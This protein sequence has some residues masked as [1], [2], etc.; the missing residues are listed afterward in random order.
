MRSNQRLA[1][2]WL[3]ALAT[4]LGASAG[5]IATYTDDLNLAPF[6]VA[7][8]SPEQEAAPGPQVTEAQ[9]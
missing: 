3:D 8:A 5:T 6:P 2:L 4:E 7:P 1:E 9:P